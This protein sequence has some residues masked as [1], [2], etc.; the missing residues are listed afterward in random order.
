LY[1]VRSGPKSVVDV[2]LDLV[3]WH[4]PHK[5]PAAV[6]EHL[7][8]PAEKAAGAIL[9]VPLFVD[10]LAPVGNSA[11][12]DPRIVTVFHALRERA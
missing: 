9:A 12:Y 5:L 7:Y 11:H 3:E 1:F 10:R 6:L 8:L 4:K 2:Y